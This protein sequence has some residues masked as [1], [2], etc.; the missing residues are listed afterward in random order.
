MSGGIERSLSNDAYQASI[1]ANAPSATNPFVTEKEMPYYDSISASISRPTQT[2]KELM[3]QQSNILETYLTKTFTPLASKNH[4]VTVGFDWSINTTVR[5]FIGKVTMV[6]PGVN[7][8]K[9]VRIESKDSTGPGKIVNVIQGGAIVGSSNTL[10]N[11]SYPETIVFN[12]MLTAGANYVISFD[13]G[14]DGI[15]TEVTV[16]NAEISLKEEKFKF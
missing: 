9:N 4:V 8:V 6:G 7:I 2:T 10:T 14:S 11:I 5:K 13:F 12:Q 1:K 16:H 3:N 15:N